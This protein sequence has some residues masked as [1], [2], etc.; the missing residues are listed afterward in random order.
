[1]HILIP[2]K[3]KFKKIKHMQKAKIFKNPKINDAATLATLATLA[4]LNTWSPK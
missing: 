1:L 4:H 2:G 3:N